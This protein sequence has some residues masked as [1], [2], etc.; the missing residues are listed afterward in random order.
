MPTINPHF[1]LFAAATASGLSAVYLDK[2]KRHKSVL[3][4]L[5]N[6]QCTNVNNVPLLPSLPTINNCMKNAY[7]ADCIMGNIVFLQE[8]KRIFGGRVVCVC[9]RVVVMQCS[10]HKVPSTFICRYDPDL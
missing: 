4:E 6:I 7:P 10:L 1:F 5:W 8:A 2:R 9:V 3:F